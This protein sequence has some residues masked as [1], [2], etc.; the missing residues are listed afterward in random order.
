MGANTPN[1]GRSAIT[2]LIPPVSD[3]D[4]DTRLVPRGSG[5]SLCVLSSLDQIPSRRALGCI[6]AYFTVTCLVLHLSKS[7]NKHSEFKLQR[8]SHLP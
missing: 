5:R 7:V 8:T 6:G 3:L 2:P 1:P 4:S